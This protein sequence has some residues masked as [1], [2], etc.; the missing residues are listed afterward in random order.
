MAHVFNLLRGRDLIWNYVTNH[1]LLGKP[2]AE[3]DLL[4]WNGDT[5]NLPAKWHGSYLTDLYRDNLLVKPGALSVDGTADRPDPRDHA[6]LCP[7]RAR[8]PYRARRERVG[9]H[10]P[11]CRAVALRAGGIGPYPRAWSTRPP[12]ANIN[13]GPTNARV[14]SLDEFVAGASETKGSWWPDWLAWLRA[15]GAETVAATGARVPGEGS[16]PA[17][18]P[19]PGSYVRAR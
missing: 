15:H 18:E 3:F 7:G 6:R 13:I 9:D 19:A 17:I 2:Y 1:Y 10:A 8:G 11:P 5:T 4:H 12:E 14:S 16:L